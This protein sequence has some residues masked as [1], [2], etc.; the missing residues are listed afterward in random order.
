MRALEQ[1][2]DEIPEAR[3]LMAACV[4]KEDLPV[5][6]TAVELHALV[7]L[8]VKRKVITP[9]EWAGALAAHG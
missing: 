8:L 6:G 3:E 1:V 9:D 2:A 4:G 7:D 5:A